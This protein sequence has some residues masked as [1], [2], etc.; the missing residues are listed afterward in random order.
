MY[1]YT[2]THTHRRLCLYNKNHSISPL[3]GPKIDISCPP[4]LRVHTSPPSG[5]ASPHPQGISCSP[6]H[7]PQLFPITGAQSP[8]TPPRTHGKS[9]KLSSSLL[10]SSLL[11][12]RSRSAAHLTVALGML[13]DCGSM[14]SCSG[15]L[16][17]PPRR[18]P[19]SG[20]LVERSRSP[21]VGRDAPRLRGASRCVFRFRKILT[22]NLFHSC[23]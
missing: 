10:A 18:R 6:A 5:K 12:S 13:E 20:W 3:L 9:Q 4:P 23:R 17:A 22:R 16:P 11:S 15:L 19:N 21:E 7:G 14:A 8:L 2:H 1:K